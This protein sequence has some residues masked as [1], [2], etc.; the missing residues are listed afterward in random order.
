MRDYHLEVDN[1]IWIYG[2]GFII[3]IFIY[4][5]FKKKKKKGEKKGNRRKL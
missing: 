1:K 4:I 3:I 5:Y 2:V